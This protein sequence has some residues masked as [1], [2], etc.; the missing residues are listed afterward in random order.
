M[1]LHECACHKESDMQ[2]VI[3]IRGK[4]HEAN[5][6]RI[7]SRVLST[8]GARPESDDIVRAIHYP[9]GEL[10]NRKLI[11]SIINNC[12]PSPCLNEVKDSCEIEDLVIEALVREHLTMQSEWCNMTRH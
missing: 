2:S 9:V 8:V 1:L 4:I 3:D 11:T 10:D 6:E 5:V 12:F 7:A